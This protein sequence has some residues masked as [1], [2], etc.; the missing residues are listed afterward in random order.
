M[1]HKANWK[2]KMEMKTSYSGKNITRKELE[3]PK[4]SL[5]YPTD[6]TAIHINPTW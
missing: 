5:T 6:R 4:K 3:A 1:F 2:L